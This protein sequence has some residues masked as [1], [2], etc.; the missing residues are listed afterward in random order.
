M[1]MR[2]LIVLFL[3]LTTIYM[4]DTSAQENDAL[5][6]KWQKESAAHRNPLVA[7]HPTALPDRI[8]L[9]PSAEG[10]EELTITW[11]TDTTVKKGTVE[12]QQAD[13]YTFTKNN[14]I[15]V[16]STRTLVEHED[17][18]MFYHEAK[19]K[20]LQKHVTYQYRVGNNPHWSSWTVYKD[21]SDSDTLSILYFGDAQ[22]RIYQNVTKLYHQAF[23]RFPETD[24]VIHAGDLINHADNDYEWAEWHA[25]AASLNRS[26]PMITTPGNHEYLK[27]LDGRKV[28]LSAYWK[29]S[30]PFPYAWEQGPYYTDYEHV[31]FI[32]LNSN[33]SLDK[34]GV[35]LDSV[36]TETKKTWTVI[37]THH[38]VF[39]GAKDRQNKGLLENWLPVIEKHQDKI[40][41]VLQGHDHTYARGGL[42]NRKHD[43]NNPSNPVFTVTVVGDKYYPLYEQPWMD[44]S[45]D[46]TS[47]YQ[48]IFITKDK[49]IYRAFSET[50]EKIDFFEINR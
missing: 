41:L 44:V 21:V 26:I 49:I 23:K 32:V 46:K 50:N 36:L 15:R 22:N 12:F 45:Y 2:F 25:A 6:Q 1:M 29:P 38:P 19:I 3:S 30:F 18:A 13:G 28:Q 35:W 20:G 37:L 9:L 8:V 10:T 11:R 14:A 34:Q 43:R 24:L 47:S 27:N 4:P 7:Y 42:E 40:G 16:K 31:R 39:S 48:S 17:Y 5:L 33:A